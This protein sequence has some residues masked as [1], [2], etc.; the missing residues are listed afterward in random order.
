M[1]GMTDAHGTT[2]AHATD[3]HA[4][5]PQGA[6]GA[7]ASGFT[8]DDLRVFCEVAARGSF[9]AAADVVGYTQSG[10]SRRV[11]ALERATGGP[12]FVRQPRGVRLTAAGEVLHRHAEAV[13]GALLTARR[14]VD[15]VR[16][17]VGGRLRIGAFATANAIVVPTA[18]A[19]LRRVAPD[20]RTTVTEAL[21]HELLVALRAGSLD[22]AL[23][24]DYPA[25][26]VHAEG[27]ELEHICDDPL[28]VALP[29]GHRLETAP[30]VD[31]GDLADESWI[32][33]GRLAADAVTLTAVAARAG[34]VPRTDITVP[35]WTAKQGF[36]AAG[37]G[38]TLVPRLAAG[39]MRPDI[40]LR[41]L[42]GEGVHRRVYLATVGRADRP[43]VAERFAGLV[44]SAAADLT[45]SRA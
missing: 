9:T 15:A 26:Q 17:G 11:A 10:V 43:E 44:R 40:V 25:G 35:G 29:A 36:V 39:A 2:T 12:L 32:E 18:V 24:S 41:P 4:T 23:V 1:V 31:V 6:V 22:V 16:A 34:F 14:E 45:A 21:T 8:V 7:T 37:L 27:V 3:P 30:A 38:I 42:R 5:S 19:A 13:L 20:V 33:A 28:L